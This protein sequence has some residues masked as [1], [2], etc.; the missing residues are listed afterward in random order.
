MS[1]ATV[2][3]SL[4]SVLRP[5]KGE[6]TRAAIVDAGL[7]IARRE[8]LEG[9]S[10]GLLADAMKM[11][12]SGVFAHFGSRE[13]LQREVLVEY[14]RRFV[15][16][17]L[18]P[19]VRE[20]RGL[21]RLNA[22]IDNWLALLAQEIAQGCLMIGGSIEYDDRPG[23]LR[24][25][26]VEIIRGWSGE[27]VTAISQ[28]RDEGHLN[29]GVDAKQLAFEIYGLMLVY[30]Q[31]A[32]LLHAKDSA[33][34]ARAGLRRL[35]DDAAAVSTVVAPR[36]RTAARPVKRTATATRAATTTRRKPR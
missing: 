17:V 30:H 1:F 13:E 25:A 26:M 11:S 24:D 10:I 20:P 3:D 7:A 35:L 29:A 22:I 31:N 21:P 5:S 15:A 8:G 28:A 6:Q 9:L 36:P 2:L 19:A 18:A 16:R 33:Q 32:R 23:V 4:S 14:A 34:R 27:V 12:K